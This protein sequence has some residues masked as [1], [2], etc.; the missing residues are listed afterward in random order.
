[1]TNTRSAC[2]AT[3]RCR[4]RV[5]A[6]VPPLGSYF[7]TS[8]PVAAFTA[9]TC[10]VGVVAYST[11]STTTGLLCISEAVKWSP[12]SNVHATFNCFTFSRV[13]WLSGE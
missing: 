7:H 13:I 11:P 4:K 3:P 8:L 6:E 1:M 10:I 9:T 12:L 5:R 2:T